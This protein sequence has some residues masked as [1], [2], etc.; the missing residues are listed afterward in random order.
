MGSTAFCYF[1]YAMVGNGGSL[2]MFVQNGRTNPHIGLSLFW[3]LIYI[4]IYIY[5][6]IYI[7]I[8]LSLS[9]YFGCFKSSR[10]LTSFFFLKT[11]PRCHPWLQL[12]QGRR[13]DSLYNYR[14]AVAM[15]WVALSVSQGNP[16]MFGQNLGGKKN[17]AFETCLG[18][19]LKRVVGCQYHSKKYFL[20][21]DFFKE[22]V[23]SYYEICFEKTHQATAMLQ[24]YP[25][26][27]EDVLVLLFF[28]V[29]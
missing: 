29:F 6:C 4:Y 18:V 13:A 16:K 27:L 9:T 23:D 24:R 21:V 7:Y 1:I 19:L 11:V 15:N 25:C 12:W 3:T 5:L 8:S 2:W 20:F 28:S 14:K 26:F 17:E 22:G 10:E